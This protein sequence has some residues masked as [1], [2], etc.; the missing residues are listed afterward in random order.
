M[1]VTL[2]VECAP[3]KEEG[4]DCEGPI[5]GILTPLVEAIPGVGGFAAAAWDVGCAA[6]KLANGGG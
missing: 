3:I 6:S 1:K 5:V 2:E 4:F